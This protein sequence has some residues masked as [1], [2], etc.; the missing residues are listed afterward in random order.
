[1]LRDPN[2]P[3]SVTII[4]V[5]YILAGAMG[6]V[7]HLGEFKAHPF[8][9]GLIAIEVVRVLAIVAGVYMLR[10]DNWARWLALAWMAFHVGISFLNGWVPVAMHAAFLAVI[11]FFLLR[12]PAREFF[13]AEKAA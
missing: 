8:P 9:W 2:R 7:Y 11:A 10:G 1:M 6:L 4:G 5:L 13:G 12:R 3:L